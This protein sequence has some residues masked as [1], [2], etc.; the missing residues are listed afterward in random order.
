MLII[1]IVVGF[2]LSSAGSQAGVCDDLSGFKQLMAGPPR[3]RYEYRGRYV[4]W[5]YEYSVRIPKGL[6]GYD[7]RDEPR[8]NGFALAFDKE[9]QSAIFVSGDPNSIEYNTP[10]EA[11]ARDVEFLRQQGKKIESETITE[12]S[13][14]TLDAV[15]LVVNYTC[16]GSAD[17]YVKSSVIAL[18]PNKRFLYTLELYSPANRY[19][20]DR[21]VLD[22]I[23]KSWKTISG[24]RRQRQRYLLSCLT[25]GVLIDEG[26]DHRRDL[27][28]LRAL[29]G[30]FW[31]MGLTEE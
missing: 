18:S 27:F 2:L 9:L 20:S 31:L 14:G 8:H 7:G 30:C 22:G 4:N 25:V 3:S 10:R 1:S 13:L 23:I 17:R 26:L 24:S 16:M 12:S 15:L 5:A 6:I 19:E 21:A 11:A 29:T 28:L